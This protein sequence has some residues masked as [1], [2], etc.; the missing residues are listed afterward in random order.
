L[1]FDYQDN[2]PRSNTWGSFPLFLSDGHLQ[3]WP[4]S[5]TTATDWTYWNRKT[6]TLFGE[7]S[8]T[9]DSGWI[10]HTNVSRRVFKEDLELFYVFG[11][12][13]PTTGLGLDPFVSKSQ[14]KTVEDSLDVYA[15]GP[16]QL[17]GRKHDLVGG[18]NISRAKNTG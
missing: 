2:R 18:F 11:F 5:V 1:G 7:L 13:D 17:G 8:H 12:P 14:D 4:R 9:F 6:Q 3:D 10:L 16:F 15:S